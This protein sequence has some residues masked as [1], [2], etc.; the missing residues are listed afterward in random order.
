MRGSFQIKYGPYLCT[1]STRSICFILNLLVEHILIRRNSIFLLFHIFYINLSCFL[2]RANF[3][4][5]FFPSCN[6]DYVKRRLPD[7]AINDN[8]H[9]F[10]IPIVVNIGGQ[11]IPSVHSESTGLQ[12]CI[13]REQEFYS[14]D[15]G[16]YHFLQRPLFNHHCRQ[17]SNVLSG[18]KSQ[19]W[20]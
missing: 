13:L 8:A 2:F 10:P 20:C 7:K 19:L 17:N 5:D 1:D 18:I 6:I 4:H 12:Y 3:Q 16:N 9:H 15:S 11:E 14:Y